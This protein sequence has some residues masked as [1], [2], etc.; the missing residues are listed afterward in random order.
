MLSH[1]LQQRRPD[2]QLERDEHRD[3]V[4]RQA[5]ERL[6]LHQAKCL[7]RPR[8]HRHLVALDGA[9]ALEDPLHH[10]ALTHGHPTGR[11]EHVGLGQARQDG[12]PQL[13]LVVGDDAE[14]EGNRTGLGEVAPERV[15]VGVGDLAVGRLGPRLDE[16]VARGE[17]GDPDPG[18]HQRP[19]VTG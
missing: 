16:L 11:D 10:I 7:G 8:L 13:V 5:E 18:M 17:D 14:T 2:E 15:R 12:R 9:E 1:H 4:A 3:G 6:A 19:R